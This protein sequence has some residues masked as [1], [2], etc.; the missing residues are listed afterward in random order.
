[1]RTSIRLYGKTFFSNIRYIDKYIRG[2]QHLGNRHQ[3]RLRFFK[4]F[5]NCCNNENRKYL[6]VGV[7]DSKIGKN[8]I[9]VDLYDK[10]PLV[11]F[12]FDI[13]SLEFPDDMFDGIV[14]N[15]ILEHVDDPARAI[16]E[17]YRVLRPTGKI[18]VEVPLNQPYHPSPN[19]Y[20]R[21]TPE[22]LRLWMRQFK[23]VSCG[24][25]F[26]NN[27]AIYTG[28]YFYGIKP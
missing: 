14:C 27:S 20:W 25:F 23:E 18:W 5:L 4:E 6:Q 22:G 2:A 8:W 12:N 26:I 21:V 11:D 1:M 3:D 24:G 17:L 19:D 9:C 15:A 16:R 13:R 10:S 7:R 28:V